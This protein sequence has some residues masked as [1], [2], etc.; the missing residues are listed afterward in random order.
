MHTYELPRVLFYS[1]QSFWFAESL[2]AYSILAFTTF[3]VYLYLFFVSL[4]RWICLFIFLCRWKPMII[5]NEDGIHH[6]S[7][8]YHYLLWLLLLFFHCIENDFYDNRQ[9]LFE[10][11]WAFSKLKF[12]LRAKAL[13][14]EFSFHLIRLHWLLCHYLL[15]CIVICGWLSIA[16]RFPLSLSSSYGFFL[17]LL[18]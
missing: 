18:M 1:V 6:I 16:H 17:I 7:Y 10:F 5:Q 11:H 12:S 9:T 14:W 3:I 4:S 13:V 2:H 15:N 8:C